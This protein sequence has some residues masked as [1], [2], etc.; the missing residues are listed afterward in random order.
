MDLMPISNR[1][2]QSKV[3]LSGET[4]E[5]DA[6]IREAMRHH[7]NDLISMAEFLYQLANEKLVGCFLE[8][9]CLPLEIGEKCYLAILT[10]SDLTH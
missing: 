7:H 5:V 8:T 6:I 9:L 3:P 2:I 10:R 1:N 4:P